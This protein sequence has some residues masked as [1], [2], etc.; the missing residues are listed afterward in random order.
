M[1]AAAAAAAAAAIAIIA[2][3]TTAVQR[4]GGEYHL[5]EGVFVQGQH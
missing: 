1:T 5:E 3:T 4:V 2:V